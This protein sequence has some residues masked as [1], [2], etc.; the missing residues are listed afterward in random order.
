MT[1]IPKE[2][3]VVIERKSQVT[4]HSKHGLQKARVRG[5]HL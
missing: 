3:S 5:E 2:I 1:L 4:T